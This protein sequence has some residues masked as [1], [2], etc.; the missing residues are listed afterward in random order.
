MKTEAVGYRDGAVELEGFIAYPDGPG[1]RPGVLVVHEW[2]GHNAYVRQR[3]EML[4]GLGYVGFAVDLFGKGVTATTTEEAGKLYTAVMSDRRVARGRIGAALDLIRAN[5]A[6]DPAKV[7][8]L[9]YCMGGTVALDLARS[10][11]DL[12]G[13]VSFHGALA[14]PTPAGK[15]AVK[16]PVLVLH[17]AGRRRHPVQRGRRPAVVG[18]HEVV[19]SRRSSRDRS[20]TTPRPRRAAEVRHA[21]HLQRHR[22]VRRDPAHG[23]LHGRPHH[24][25]LPAPAADGRL[26]GDGHVPG[27][28]PAAGR[29]R[30]Q[31]AGQ[32]GASNSP[33]CRGRRWW[34]SRTSTTRRRRPRSAR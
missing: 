11:A 26:R 9:G 10:G 33:R 15:A 28:R 23:R 17:A 1:C 14:T 16:C 19:S 29:R 22:T 7:V 21:D 8:C 13:A 34:C 5:P 2:W 30:L 18:S 31:R 12:R 25:V 32:A 6:V 3:A 27:R 20:P 4:A 24:G